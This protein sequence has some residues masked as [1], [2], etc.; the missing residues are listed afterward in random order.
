MIWN[1]N[2]DSPG[3]IKLLLEAQDLAMCKK[4]GQNFLISPTI[5]SRI[6]DEL[7]VQRGMTVWE[8]G[9]GIGSLTKELLGRGASVTGFEI[10]HGFCRVL[11]EFAFPDEPSFTLVEGDVLSTMKEQTTVPKRICGN[12]PYNI[13]SVCLAQLM[14]SPRRPE[15]MIFTL[16]R[17]VA[18]RICASP[19]SKEWSTLS[20]LCQMDYQPLI[21]FAIKAGC[22]YPEP[23]VRS[24]VLLFER[25]KEGKIPAGLKENFLMVVRDLFAQR[26]KTIRNNLLCGKIGETIL[27]SGVSSILDESGVSPSCRGEELDWDALLSLTNAF[28]RYVSSVPSDNT[29]N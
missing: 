11:R 22:F 26:R 12:L 14:E 17:E 5:R 27:A 1:F 4:F 20:I 9:P 8:I 29:P 25:R 7:D 16:Q 21:R 23:N 24:S 2:Y 6:A 13:G 3:A 28:S 15:R 19:G 10:D 18:E